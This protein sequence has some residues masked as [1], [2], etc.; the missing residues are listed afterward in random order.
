MSTSFPGG[1]FFL[2]GGGFWYIKKGSEAST[3]WEIY[4]INRE[5]VGQVGWFTV[6]EFQDS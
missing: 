3:F 1:T 6:L 5:L 2:G 4:H